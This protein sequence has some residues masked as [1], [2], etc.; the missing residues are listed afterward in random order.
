MADSK[1]TANLTLWLVTANQYLDA[2]HKIA[3]ADAENDSQVKQDAP[4]LTILAYAF[5]HLLKISG[6]LS[7]L[8]FDA[9]HDLSDLWKKEKA[10]L[11]PHMITWTEDYIQSR[12][13]SIPKCFEAAIL[14]D[15]PNFGYPD[16]GFEESLGRLNKWTAHPFQ[17]R[18]PKVLGF[19]NAGSTDIRF[20][21][22]IGLK[23]HDYLKLLVI[24]TRNND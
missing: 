23:L 24:E 3:I 8:K 2:V 12:R 17:S 19:D 4:T 5:E 18:Y 9:I 14:D 22:F 10:S 20:L 6:Q 7:N 11:S 15:N 16:R 1:N 21:H 13:D